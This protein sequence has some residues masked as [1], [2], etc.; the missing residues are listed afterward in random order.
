MYDKTPIIEMLQSIEETL[1]FLLERTAEI[2]S[3]GDF[4]STPQGVEKLDFVTIRL[5]ATG[6]YIHKINNKTKGELL[7]NYPEVEWQHVVGFRNFVAHHYF[8]VDAIDV[9]RILQNE[10]N[11]LLSTIQKIIADLNKPLNTK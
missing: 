6:E 5:M 11:P 9:F 7:K 10:V 4:T 1:L 3:A 2:K 8:K